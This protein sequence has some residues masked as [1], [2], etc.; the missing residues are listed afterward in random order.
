MRLEPFDEVMQAALSPAAFTTGTDF[1]RGSIG[2]WTAYFTS[3][4]GQ[5]EGSAQNRRGARPLVR[6]GFQSSSGHSIPGNPPAEMRIRLT[7]LALDPTP[8]RLKEAG[9]AIVLQT[10]IPLRRTGVEGASEGMSQ[11]SAHF[12][13]AFFSPS[14]MNSPSL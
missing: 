10:D 1:N 11:S 3:T 2:A 14:S 13:P 7:Q 5:P 6:L 4:V 12:A 8:I 9:L